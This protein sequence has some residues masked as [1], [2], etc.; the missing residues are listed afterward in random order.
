MIASTSASPGK[1]Y[2]ERALSSSKLEGSGLIA[3]LCGPG[4]LL[5]R[6]N[7]GGVMEV[8]T[9]GKIGRSC[10]WRSRPRKSCGFVE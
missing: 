3:V 9:G 6:R 2:D 7:H 4:S 10:G 1:E 5:R 8:S